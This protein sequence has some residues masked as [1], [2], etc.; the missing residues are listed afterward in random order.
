MEPGV[1]HGDHGVAK[2]RTR[3]RDLT[4]PKPP[5][6]RAQQKHAQSD[7]TAHVRSPGVEPPARLF[8][9]WRGQPAAH[10]CL[11]FWARPASGACLPRLLGAVRI[12]VGGRR[13]QGPLGRWR[14]W[15]WLPWPPGYLVAGGAGRQSPS[16][17][18]VVPARYLHGRPSGRHSGSEVSVRKTGVRRVISNI[19][20]FGSSRPVHFWR[21]VQKSSFQIL[22]T[23]FF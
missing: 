21:S 2:S 14:G 5:H 12:S 13:A 16:A 15:V 7:D 22:S 11:G 1:L 18:T 9:S 23:P 3:R 8:T 17:S 20:D 4:E 19:P 10:A 6:R